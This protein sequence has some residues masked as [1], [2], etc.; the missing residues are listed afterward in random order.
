MKK[1]CLFGLFA[2]LPLL[3]TSC[4]FL[5]NIANF[6]YSPSSE[7][8]QDES[9]LVDTFVDTKGRTMHFATN[10]DSLTLLVGMKGE[11]IADLY[12]EGSK[13]DFASRWSGVKYKSLDEGVAKVNEDGVVTALKLGET[14]IRTWMFTD[15]GKYIPVSVIEKELESIELSNCR[16][17]YLIDSEFTPKFDLTATFKGNIKEKVNATTV[18]YSAVNTHQV[19]EYP[20]VVSYTFGE[21]T[22]SKTYTVNIIE[23]ASYEAKYLS[24]TKNDLDN[25]SSYAAGNGWYCPNKGNVKMLVIPVWF[26]DSNRF[27]QASE[28]N[29]LKTAIQ[30]AFFGASQP[31]GWESVKT[32]YEKES[33]NKVTINGVVSDYFEPS[34]STMDITNEVKSVNDVCED[35]IN[36]YFATNTSEHL[37]DYD[38]DNNG[39]TDGIHILYV[40]PDGANDDNT[41]HG[42]IAFRQLIAANDGQPAVT[43]TMWASALDAIADMNQSPADSHVFIHEIG[44]TFG[45]NDYYDYG[46]EEDENGKDYRPAGG[47]ITME[48]NT[49]SQDPYS[50][51]L[52]KWAKV[53][54][55]EVSCTIELK[56]FQSSHEMIVLSNH[57]YSFDSPF[58]E[59]IILELYNPKG[60]NTFDSTYSWVNANGAHYSTGPQNP[61]IRV[62]HIDSRLTKKVAGEF[63][64]EL[65]TNPLEKDAKQAFTNTF[66]GD[67]HVDI[68]GSDYFDY[69][70]IFGIRNDVEENKYGTKNQII[71]DEQLFHSGDNFSIIK[72]GKQFPIEGKMNDGHAFAW[73][74]MVESI[75]SDGEGGYSAV[76]NLSS[77]I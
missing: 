26:T 33:Q 42:M 60:L 59:Y 12:E 37:S 46:G 48:H 50:C 67:T 15:V 45:L 2:I 32:F 40:C 9:D 23:S 70:E 13:P 31:N 30:N 11:I 74:F 47:F 75:S 36:W 61:G 71:K 21:K 24:Y 65:F 49:G 7:N 29:T 77:A 52:M 8:V 44:H 6:S 63:T 72:F 5:N 25:N 34:Y 51:L 38:S 53:I 3:L 19:G 28:K 66:S 68:L 43:F 41:F 76:I 22:L 58:D 57:P 17:T 14:K 4:N 10:V 64:T 39:V 69:S 16:K 18:D 1:K 55:P 73:T 54:V 35:A 20:V 56:D 62:Y 27:H